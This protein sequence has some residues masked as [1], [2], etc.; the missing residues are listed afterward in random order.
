LVRLSLSRSPF[1]IRPQLIRG[2]GTDVAILLERL[3]DDV[4]ELAGTR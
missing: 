3:R 4:V 2:P 1:E